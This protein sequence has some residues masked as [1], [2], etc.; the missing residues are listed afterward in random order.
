MDFILV[1][2]VAA[3]TFGLC[4]LVDRGFTKV[5]RGKAQH[6]T[7]LSVR[8]NK[9]Y[10]VAGIVLAVLGAAAV[11]PGLS[12]TVLL[13]VGGAV[14]IL[15]GAAMIAYYLSFGIYY[16]AD[17]FL[18]SSFGK[19]SAA[20]AFR[21]IRAQQLYNASGNIVI[22]LHMEDG[23]TVNLLAGMEGVYPF[24]DAAFSAWCRQ[25]GIDPDSCT[26]HDTSTSCWFPP[27]EEN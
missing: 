6:K 21:D 24:L 7:G 22:E 4:Y 2:L 27:V 3:A 12:G 10:G 15:T 26:F 25:R 14:L 1:M 23:R 17:S 18:L 16:D 13:I 19:K 20:Y 5:F 8:A 11:L 9:L